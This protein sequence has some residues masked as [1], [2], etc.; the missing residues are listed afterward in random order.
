MRILVA[1]ANGY[2][3]G[4]ISEYLTAQG[5]DITALIHHKSADWDRR[6]SKIDRVVKGD[7]RNKNLLL[8]AIEGDVDCIVFTISLDHRRSSNNPFD[9]L[10]TNVGILW[11][12]LDICA[13]KGKGKLIYLSTQQVYG[14][15]KAGEVICEEDTLLPVNPYGLAHK[16]C[17]DLCSL[18]SRERGLDCISLR[19]SNSFGAP[20]FSS[21]NCWWLAI[22]DFCKTA[23]GHG[24]INLLSDGSPQRDFIPI[25][26]V[27]KAIEMLINL[28]V[29][30]LPH[31]IYNLGSGKTHTIL[32]LAHAV[33]SICT[34][35]YGKEFPVVLPGGN[36]SHDT[37]Q[38]RNIPRFTYDISRLRSLGFAPSDKLRPGIEEVLNFLEKPSHHPTS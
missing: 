22:N 20:A 6:L 19:L 14:K 30:T 35:R 38:H 7:A 31:R 37:G 17:E 21:C 1:G 26:D 13:E 5:N 10:S 29:S 28:P 24:K 4:R 32:E 23:L 16:Y 2:L 25:S 9:T 8:S 27:C 12:L 33:A 3:G 18:Y 34:D 36:I 11:T 15:S